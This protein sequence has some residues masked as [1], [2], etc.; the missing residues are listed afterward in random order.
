[1]N[2]VVRSF[3]I[4]FLLELRHR[5][6]PLRNGWITQGIKISSKKIRFLNMLKKQ[7]NLTED[8]K[9]YIAKYKIIYKRVI[10]EAKRREMM[11]TY[12]MKITNL[13]LYGRL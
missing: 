13:K 8:A 10:R 1:M 2:S 7:P 5:K 9:M 12:C 4:A 11:S 6:K 3:A